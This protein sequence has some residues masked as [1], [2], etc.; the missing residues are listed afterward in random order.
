MVLK[1]TRYK[2]CALLFVSLF[3]VNIVIA[4]L[5]P[6]NIDFENG[7]FDG[8]T[9]STGSVFAVGNNNSIVLSNSGGP[10]DMRHTIIPR[11]SNI[12]V[13]DE[14]GNFPVNCPNGSAYSVKLGNTSG[15]HEAEGVSY[16]FTIPAGSNVYSLLYHYAVVFQNPN[17]Q[18]HQ[19][20]R[21]E[22][23]VKNI[24]DNITI[25]CSSFTFIPGTGLPG[26]YNS[27]RTDSVLCKSWTPVTINLN[28]N[29]GKTIKITF[30]SADCIFNRHFGYAYIDVNTE[31][32]GEFP[33]ASYCIDDTAVNVV[34]PSGFA[35]YNWYTNNFTTALGTSQTLFLQPP[36]P[37][38]TPI[39]VIVT[40][41]NG[42]G[43]I[44]TLYA[45]LIDTLSYR[46]N[47]G[48][49]ALLC[50]VDGNT[51]V[52]VNPKQGFVYE[53]T[54]ALGLSDASASNPIAA[55][56][57]S[58]TYYLNVRNGGGGCRSKDTVVIRKSIVDT[59]MQFIGKKDFCS[60]SNDS[61]VFVVQPQNTIQWYKNNVPI[62][63][64]NARR[65]RAPS[66]GTYYAVLKDAE[67]CVDNTRKETVNIEVPPRG[68]TYPDVFT[69]KNDVLPLLARNFR[70]TYLWDPPTYL[71][72]AT[73]IN[74]DFL[75]PIATTQL[76][77]INIVTAAG[78]N[79]VDFQTVKVINEILFFVPN[80]FTP[81]GDAINDLFTPICIGAT[82]KTFKVYNRFGQ[83]VF[84]SGDN[85]KGWNGKFK[86]EQQ[87]PATYVWYLEAIGVNKKTYTRKGTVIL[88]R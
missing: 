71:N 30:K 27:P 21:L 8:W 50:G 58:T 72:N 82:V 43:C 29:A 42:Y 44:D 83:Q 2:N 1:F 87:I 37:T 38:G 24:T 5:C 79:V 19:Q 52:G 85:E 64:A 51:T 53:W 7:S 66:Q 35:A 75:S 78:C 70:G 40:P 22:I 80:A 59:S 41:F 67:G 4:Q 47:A 36:P 13:Y 68:I 26:F 16:E 73:A 20:P 63:A 15:G 32:N 76:Y 56:A 74:P 12:G 11:A 62:N 18:A 31:C 28:G 45:T 39:A 14:Y 23:E 49:D 88:I 48:A 69:L 10:Q 46:A 61:A 33:G 54:P 17:H 60:V 55:P 57:L 9:C 86:G 6:Q 84:S 77:R 3:I 81:N 65:Y 25:D 34:G